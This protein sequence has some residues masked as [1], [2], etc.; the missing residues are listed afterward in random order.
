MFRKIASLLFAL[1]LP[2]LA[3]SPVMAVEPTDLLGIPSVYVTGSGGGGVLEDFDIT[4]QGTG[5]RFRANPIAGFSVSGAAGVD[6]GLIRVEGEVF[7]NHNELDDLGGFFGPFDGDVQALAGMANLYLDIPTGIGFT[8]FIGGGIGFA[9]VDAD[10]D[11][12]GGSF[13]NDTDNGFAWQ[14]R[15]G[16]AVAIFPYTDLTFGYR[17]F[18]TDDLSMTNAT[19]SVEVEGLRSHIGEIGLRITF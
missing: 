10:L 1:S 16:I 12:G 17:Y 9:E 15:A 19:G 18:A 13:L 2:I 5:N 6:F 8:P 3:T 14:L 7:Y 4:E 11:A